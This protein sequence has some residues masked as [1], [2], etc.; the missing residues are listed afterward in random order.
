MDN[1]FGE[2]VRAAR[3]ARGLTQSE[4]AEMANISRAYFVRIEKGLTPGLSY[5]KRRAI[6]KVLGLE[7]C[8]PTH[9]EMAII[10]YLGEIVKMFEELEEYNTMCTGQ[11]QALMHSA[12]DVVLARTGVRALKNSIPKEEA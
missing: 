3:K 1:E 7:E 5:V 11:F 10:T 6:E 9:E 4:L 12:Q 8:G 2:Q